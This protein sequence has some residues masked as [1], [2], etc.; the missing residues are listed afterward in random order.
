[1]RMHLT[2][3]HL[4]LRKQTLVLR[5]EFTSLSEKMFLV[6]YYYLL[7]PITIPLVTQV[8]HHSLNLNGQS[9]TTIKT[10]LCLAA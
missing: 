3:M 8:S 1:M 9:C 7:L 10:R 4:Y 5:M 6:Y 2:I